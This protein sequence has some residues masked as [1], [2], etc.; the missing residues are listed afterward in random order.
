MSDK[1]K[2]LGANT[3]ELVA[4]VIAYAKQETV[5]PI[6]SLGRYVAFGL[7]GALLFAA[8][9]VLIAVTGLRAIQFEAGSHLSGEWSWV[10]YMGGVL[11]AGTGVGWA[12]AR[13]VKGDKAV[14]GQK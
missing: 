7:I 6:K 4:L 2:G 10:P 5:V 12:V 13:I 11:L 8:G 1:D 3:S 14:G 9:G